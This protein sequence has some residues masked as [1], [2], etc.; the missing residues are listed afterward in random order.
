[1]TSAPR[2]VAEDVVRSFPGEK[3]TVTAL[4]PMS[5]EIDDR[6]FVSIVGPS[7]CGK[8]TFLRIIGGLIRPSDGRIRVADDG[9]GRPL[10]AF[11]FQD[12]SVFPWKTV[13]ENVAWTLR[14]NGASRSESAS[15]AQ[16]WVSRVG[17]EPFAD[18]YP[19]TLSG[20]MRQRVAIARAFAANPQV[21]LMDEPFAAL[22]AQMRTVMQEE[23]GR[24]CEA[25][26]RTVVFV[27]HSIDEAILLSD[28]ILVMSA[29]PGRIIGRYDVPLPR[30]RD[31][32]AVDSVEAR[33]LHR[34]V[35]THLEDEVT[36][37]MAQRSAA[38]PA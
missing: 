15:L 35:W 29:S 37:V 25:E 30:P 12:Y 8:S 32:G 4:G 24:L 38:V 2:I 11:V 19:A 7:G 20:G 23:L 34:T 26:P 13:L 1:M 31:V 3:R 36:K 21:L 28:T 22:D 9:S 10:A 27:T 33:E 14:V 16:E 5:T 17:L 6:R 18:D